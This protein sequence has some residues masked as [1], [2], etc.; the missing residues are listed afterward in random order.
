MIVVSACQA[1]ECHPETCCCRD[2][3]YAVKGEIEY[4]DSVF[5]LRKYYGVIMYGT[6]EECETYVVENGR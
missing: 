5:G 2:G 1:R 4:K 3:E 6:K